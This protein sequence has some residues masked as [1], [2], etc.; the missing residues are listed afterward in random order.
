MFLR[1]VWDFLRLPPPTAVQNDIAWHL[2]YGDTK[3]IISAFRGVGK[4]WITVAFV[5]WNLLLNPECKIMVV[6][7]NQQLADDF[8]KFCKQLIH[9]MP[10]LQHLAP[11]MDQ[12]NSQISFDVGPARPSKDPSVKSAGIT[13]QITG[14]RADIIIADDIE[15]PKNSYTHLLRER[16]SEL[17]KEFTAILKPLPTSRIIYLGTPQNEQSVYNKL[18]GRGYTRTVWPAEIPENVEKY[19]GQL[20]KLVM[21]MIERGAKAGDPT[22]PERFTR[23]ILDNGPK[24]EYGRS[25]YALQFMLDTSPSDAERHPLKLRDLLIADIDDAMG[26]VKLVWAGERQYAINDIACGGMDGDYYLRPAFRSP[27]MAPFTGRV[28]AIDPSGQGKDETAFAIIYAL[29]GMLYLAEVGGFRDGYSEATLSGLAAVAAR[30]RVNDVI[31]ERNYG[32]GMFTQMLRGALGKLN[33]VTGK[34][35]HL[36]NVEEVYHTG[37]KEVR[38]LDTLEPLFQGHKLVVSRKVIEKDAAVNAE[39]PNYSLIYQFTRLSRLKG[40]LAHDD[41]VEAVYM[42]CA[43]FTDR[44]GRDQDKALQQHKDTAFQEELKKFMNA[45][46]K[47]SGGRLENPR[48][49]VA[50]RR[51]W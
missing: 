34:P 45:A 26:W 51:R 27:E 35:V 41:R 37:Q 25:G 36:C 49:T 29:H 6:S 33:P 10:L 2:Q 44:L 9:G 17:V 50:S 48:K 4:S 8:T 11:R 31:V 23:A 3:H 7:A 1:Q 19:A 47:I 13:G 15:I 42:A 20:S 40:A 43:H 14:S 12:R 18:A 32:G 38:M 16:L 22:D 5:L 21:R 30:H 24:I 46:V 28:M 39:T